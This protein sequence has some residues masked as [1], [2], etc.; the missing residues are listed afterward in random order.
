MTPD[1]ARNA[2]RSLFTAREQARRRS[3]TASVAAYT[4]ALDRALDHYNYVKAAADRLA[5]ATALHDVDI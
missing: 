1:E 4:E 3:D 5:D 2:V